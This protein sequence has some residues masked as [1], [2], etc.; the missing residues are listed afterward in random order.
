MK[1][2]YFFKHLSRPATAPDLSSLTWNV[3]VYLYRQQMTYSLA[4]IYTLLF[5]WLISN[6]KE[7]ATKTTG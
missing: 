4:K 5:M 3:L 2:Q 1:Q 6:F 7:C